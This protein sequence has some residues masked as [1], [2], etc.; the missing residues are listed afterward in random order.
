M[1]PP[2]DPLVILHGLVRGKVQF[3]VIGG[4]AARAHGSPTATVDIDICYDRT[5]LISARSRRC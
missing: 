5:Q 4:V 3:V 1:D 2:F